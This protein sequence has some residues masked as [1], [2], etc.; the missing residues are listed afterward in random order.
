MK[1][2]EQKYARIQISAI[3]EQIGDEK[4]NDCDFFILRILFIFCSRA[5]FI[6]TEFIFLMNLILLSL[7]LQ[8][9]K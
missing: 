6:P 9:I 2:L 3:A 7:I 8:H 4:V 5:L 1:Q